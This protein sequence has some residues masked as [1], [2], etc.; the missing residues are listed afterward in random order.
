MAQLPDIRDVQDVPEPLGW[1]RE[2][3]RTLRDWVR[4]V[5]PGVQT[6][7]DPLD[8]LVTRREL[9]ELGVLR[10]S[11]GGRFLAG[12]GGG[13][14][15]IVVPGGGG[16]GGGGVTPDLTPPPTPEGFAAA[17]AI[18]NILLEWANPIYTQGGGHA[19]TRIYGVVWPAGEAPK[20]FA[21]AKLIDTSEGPTTVH[22][23]PTAPG[24][25]WALWIKWETKAGVLSTVPAGG[26]N[27]VVVTTAYDPVVLLT[28]LTGQ[29]TES[30]LFTSLGNRINLVDGS[31]SLPGS[32]NAR[33][34]AQNTTITSQWQAGDAATLGSAQSYAQTYVQGY[35][36]SSATIDGALL[37]QFNS[38][39]SQYQNAD[40]G[41][42]AQAKAYTN[43]VAFTGAD[44]TA[45]ASQVT[46]L[47]ARVNNIA[48]GANLLRNAGFDRHNG[49]LPD[50]WDGYNNAG[51]AEPTTYAIVDGP[52]G[53]KAVRVSWAMSQTSTK[54]IFQN[55][56]QGGMRGGQTYIYAC[57]ARNVS[58]M[59]GR[60]LELQR[61]NIQIAVEAVIRNPGLTSQWQWY[62]WR[63]TRTSDN[64]GDFFITIAS[65]SPAGSYEI[66]T[67]IIH[68]GSE[69]LGFNLGRD[70]GLQAALQQESTVRA[71]QTGE[72][73]AQWTVKL[74]LNGYVSG[75]GLA[76]EAPGGPVGMPPSSSFI[77]RADRFAVAAPSGPGITPMVPFIVRTTPTSEGGVPIGAGVYIDAANI[78]NLTVL[79]AR[80]ATLV[81]DSITA[82]SL[83]AAQLTAGDGTIGGLLKS[84]NYV[85]GV[86]GWQVTPGGAAEFG[87]INARGTIVAM[88]GSIGGLVVS[89]TD[90]RSSNYVPGS[91]GFRLHSDGS[92]DINS[93]TMRATLTVGTA[94]LSGTS[95][96]GAGARINA[97]GSFAIGTPD[98][99]LAFNGTDQPRL[100]GDWVATGNIQLG[101]VGA[102][103]LS[104]GVVADINNRLR[105]D[106]DEI[107]G[108]VMSVNAVAS[109]AGFRAGS[110]TWNAAGTVTGG[111]G[112]AMTPQGLVAYNGTNLTFT[113]NA[114]TGAATF[115]GALMAAT[116]TFAGSMSTGTATR[117]GSTMTGSGAALAADG[118]GCWGNETVNIT[119]DGTTIRINGP[120]VTRDNLILSGFSV[121][122]SGGNIVQQVAA[123]ASFGPGGIGSRTASA[124]GGSGTVTYE[125]TL[126]SNAPDNSAT[127]WVSGSANS[128]TVSLGAQC[129]SGGNAGRIVRVTARDANGLTAT[130]SFTALITSMS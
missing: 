54:G 7:G 83:S 86:Q 78:V 87:N 45:L 16:G 55:P 53:F 10:R 105:R 69:F 34:L 97:G 70:Y 31:A 130:A 108:A 44:G 61:S 96:T 79:Y 128:A 67:P 51:A 63:I 33:L 58:G 26:T 3:L 117:S 113:L 120:L 5:D 107:L 32:V 89:S 91:T 60:G 65:P 72:L 84:A 122:I 52:D 41:T 94:A 43:A 90:V 2:W 75:F 56:V 82:A 28:A 102:G 92:L 80:I 109:P 126:V 50:L 118:T 68:E 129:T 95:M 49:S 71:T 76:S 64:A 110:I 47:S 81:A 85:P 18:T 22:A 73:Y 103:Q 21:D 59:A 101:A 39:T 14:V 119:H 1:L 40:A 38:I 35:T 112:V 24:T 29:I 6:V 66:A 8:K 9:V 37:T 93:G 11:L 99:N 20:V 125:W 62:V 74:D 15:T 4:G 42:L 127:I 36:Y 27:G 77:I 19:R 23:Y 12:S 17:A 106:A 13:P 25:R 46:T 111:S 115:G 121:S 104:P 48:G 57:R 114:N 124:T 123:G 98:R 116:G 100:N 88:A 30:Q